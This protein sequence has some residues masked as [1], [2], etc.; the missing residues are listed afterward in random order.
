MN[1]KSRYDREAAQGSSGPTRR[2]VLGTLALGSLLALSHR[3]ASAALTIPRVPPPP[4]R[5][6]V[7]RSGDVI[8]SHKVDFSA[9]E[10]GGLA[11][12]TRIAIEVRILG[13]KAFEF[14]HQSTELWSDG[15][16]HKFDSETLDD[17]S[18]FF[19]NGHATAD[20][21]QITHRKGSELAP[22]DIMV[23][24]YWTPEIARR[25]LLIDPQRGSIKEQK[26]IG[27]DTLAVPIGS[28]SIQATR[29]T[30]VGLTKG[31]VAYDEHG[32]WLA[33]EL[34]KNGSD[35]LYVLRP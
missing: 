20:G 3:S 8:G 18:R 13:V 29:Y 10:D 15:R 5:F 21:F 33:A 26:L 19:V 12:A 34:T 22:A 31:W 1:Q 9:A 6:D 28:A 23:G 27:E 14:L 17:D 25:N 4:I 11:V 7:F 16:L 32:R 30:L 2:N 35:I 24:S